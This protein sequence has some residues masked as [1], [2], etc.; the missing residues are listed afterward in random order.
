MAIV[1]G[2]ALGLHGRTC[3]NHQD[4]PIFGGDFA[5]VPIVTV[6]RI[7]G[8]KIIIAVLLEGFDARIAVD[9]ALTG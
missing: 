4:L 2:T 3:L 7:A 5:A 8:P 1:A 6:R 9:A